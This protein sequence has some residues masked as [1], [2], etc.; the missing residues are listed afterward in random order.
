[1]EIQMYHYEWDD[2]IFINNNR[3]KR[4][5]GSKD[6]A[7]IIFLEHDIIEIKWDTWGV[8]YYALNNNNYYVVE[9]I[10]S[11]E[12]I[13]YVDYINNIVYKNNY[14]SN[15]DSV[16]NILNWTEIKNK[17]DLIVNK[18][19]IINDNSISNNYL[20]N[21]N[22]YNDN[23]PNGIPN[24]IHFI[25]GLIP[26]NE[27]F[28]MY[29]YISVKSAHDV[30]KPDKIYFYYYHEPYGHWWN[31]TKEIVEAVK[32]D[33]K[34]VPTEIYGNK[35]R[36]YAHKADILRLQKMK[37]IGGI[38]LDIDTICIKSFKDLLNNDFVMGIQGSTVNN[39][40]KE[41][42]SSI[43]DNY[44][45]CNAVILSKP[46]SYFVKKW[47]ESYKTFRS[48]GRDEYWDEHSVLKPLELSKRY[49]EHIKI[50]NKH[51][52]FYQLWNNIDNILFNSD[53]NNLVINKQEYKDII[54]NNYCIH[55]WDTYSHD[56]LKHINQENIYRDNTLYNIIA[57]KFIQNKI[58]IVFLTYN[59]YEMTV[60]CLNSYLS[61]L[62][63]D[64]IEELIVLD[65]NSDQ[66]LKDFLN[67]FQDSHDKIKIIFSNK[68][69]GVC[70]G[71]RILFNEAKGD[72]IASLDSDAKLIN[73][74]FFELC[75]DK[76]YQEH[77][78]IVGISG[79]FIRSW[80]FGTQEDIKDDDNN[81]YFCHH[82]A[83]CCQVFRRDMFLF[84][85]ELDPYY[86]KFWVEDTD[87]S[88]QFLTLGKKNYR[89]G[90]NN[91][92]KHNWGGSGSNFIELFK[93]NW[94]YFIKKWSGKIEL[95]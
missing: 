5:N 56:Y 67:Q 15:F 69:L 13:F 31:K 58:S 35:V 18:D 42:S 59:R 23:I 39:L 52:F 33:E 10:E 4:I 54:N 30:N 87:F 64:Y 2:N 70:L 19:L 85:I 95:F 20:H 44:G 79:A 14:Y 55:L 66:D 63:N 82:I 50:M 48:C 53:D 21:D 74:S 37:E 71:R 27:E 62:D 61:I 9:K 28:N 84:G 77:I 40:N 76:L 91:K 72:I 90:Q 16:E 94:D 81:E 38:Y 26:Q 57:R 51:S 73:G 41:S 49:P 22:I 8:E 7:D 24:I 92:I 12:N 32:L 86:D 60:E 47:L 89:F 78:G 80:E 3:I 1:M 75:I 93:K 88:M 11:D 46:N 65:N 29:R 6:E 36:H 43:H 83:G 68:N 25:F 17:N 45:L 34:D